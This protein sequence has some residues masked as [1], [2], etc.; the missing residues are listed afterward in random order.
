MNAAECLN[1]IH[2][3]YPQLEI[4]TYSFNN[5]GQN[6]DVLV[7]N[8]EIVFR[9]PRTPHGV[10]QLRIEAAI[11]SFLQSHV[12]LQVPNPIYLNLGETGV[13]T[14]GRPSAPTRQGGVVSG[15]VVS[16]RSVSGRPVSGVAAAR[17][18]GGAAHGGPLSGGVFPGSITSGAGAPGGLGRG[19][20]LP[21][22][23]V[24]T[25][26]PPAPEA[27]FAQAQTPS[28]QAQ[29]LDWLR[30][31]S[32]TLGVQLTS[33]QRP[34]GLR[35]RQDVRA[36]RVGRPAVAPEDRPGFRGA[37]GK[38]PWERDVFTGGLPWNRKQKERAEPRRP[39]ERPAPQGAFIGYR[40]IP[41]EPLWREAL[42][43]AMDSKVVQGWAEQLGAFLRELHALPL[44]GMLAD[45]LPHYDTR[46]RWADFYQRTQAKVFPF[47]ARGARASVAKVFEAYLSEPR[48]FEHPLTLVHGD[49]GP[50]NILLDRSSQ[51]VSGVIDFG[52]SG[53]D[54]PAV[55]CAAL[56]G[57]F[58]YGEAFLR[59]FARI[60]PIVSEDLERAR[61]Y[62]STFALQDAVYGIE[63]GDKEAFEAGMAAYR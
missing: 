49:F 34:L 40:W 59:R 15:G 35:A 63:H 30:P 2:A 60:Y 25:G 16:G 11:L 19:G 47:M 57:P 22:A 4:D 27:A 39:D 9:F 3:A 54:D 17:D 20:S 58:G 43:G 52:S 12:T 29:P 23:R 38:L 51:R 55:D 45:L 6:N 7:V 18:S 42:L 44:E 31:H 32:Q 1:I 48:N 61:F 26:K 5:T 41:G 46:T 13:R 33:W 21:G 14:A 36:R 62:A 50:G 28:G 37:D 56:I 10:R 8:D 24:S 53:L